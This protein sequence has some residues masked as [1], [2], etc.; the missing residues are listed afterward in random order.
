MIIVVFSIIPCLILKGVGE[1]ISAQKGNKILILN[2][3]NDRFVIT[4]LDLVYHSFGS[5][6]RE[7]ADMTAIDFIIAITKALNRGEQLNFS[8]NQYITHVSRDR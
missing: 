5:L 3:Y 1:A 8:P 4:A 6:C 2:G 7:T